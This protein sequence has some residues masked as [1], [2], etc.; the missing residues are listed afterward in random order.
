M[1]KAAELLCVLLLICLCVIPA[2]ADAE[3]EYVLFAVRAQGY[4]V[5]PE[6]LDMTSV[7][8]LE[9]GGKGRMTSDEDSMDITQWTLEGEAFSLTLADGSAADGVLQG[10][11]IRL[12]LYGDGSIV[13]YYAAPGAD[14]SAYSV[15]SVEEFIAQYAAD[16]AAKLSD[17]RL[18]ALSQGLDSAS[19][20]RLVYTVHQDYM[21][22]DQRYAVQ[23]RGG[24]YYSLRVTRVSGLENT[25]AV[26]FRDSTAYNLD[27]EAKTA[28]KVTTTSLKA[29]NEYALLM[30]DLYAAIVR[31]A[32]R[33]DFTQE[34]RELN[35]KEYAVEVYPARADYESAYAFYFDGEGKLA[36]CEEQHPETAGIQ[37]GTSAYTVETID[38]A[39]EDALFELTGYTITE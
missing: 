1:K 4:T 2:Y 39:V 29:V 5:V 31:N 37:L 9:K 34:V 33:T 30:D 28:L 7:L 21:D 3:N 19:G 11:V 20:L 35:G 32:D 17:S 8:T 25:A 18:Y 6:A 12:D 38:G 10:N 16:Q 26:L 13:L 23:G 22:A 27:P 15:L 36:Y 14:T 24:L